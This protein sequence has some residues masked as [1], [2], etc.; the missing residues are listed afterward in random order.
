[1]QGTHFTDSPPPGDDVTGGGAVSVS[2]GSSL[3]V[4]TWAWT[5]GAGLLAGLVSWAAGEPL[6][7]VV[8]PPMRVSRD[9]GMVRVFVTPQDM[10][11]AD[12][13]NAAL[14]FAVLGGVLATSLG[15]AGGLSRKN[16]RAAATAAFLGLVAGA[17]AS[18]GIAFLILP[19]YYAYQMRTPDQDLRGLLGPLMVHIGLWAPAGAA[20]GWAFA[21]G[22]APRG[23]R[24]AIALGGLLGA[25]AGALVFEF[26]AALAFPLDETT[27]AISEMCGARLL[28]RFAVTI[29]AAAGV[30]LGLAVSV[31]P[32]GDRPPAPSS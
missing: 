18:A 32:V 10:A 14:S 6:C 9:N 1:M 27:R 5:L 23:G 15:A 19:P 28:A 21:R 3:P 31:L 17:A 4:A 30:L 24:R 22:L 25:T 20:G 29:C 12:T 16:G 13:R 11:A 26:V 2:R 7:A 8:Q